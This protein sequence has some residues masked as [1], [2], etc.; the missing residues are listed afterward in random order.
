M[1]KVSMS[2]EMLAWARCCRSSTGAPPEGWEL[3]RR[4]GVG[5]SGGGVLEHRVGS[6]RD[7][8]V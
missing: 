5:A 1:V 7:R 8:G 6:H 4:G 2:M 3:V